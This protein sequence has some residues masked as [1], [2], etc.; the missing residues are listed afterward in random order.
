ME[1][2]TNSSE[3]EILF[4]EKCCELC[5]Y[6][7][8]TEP[9]MVIEYRNFENTP[10]DTNIFNQYNRTGS[11]VEYVV[12][13]ALLL[14]EN[15]P[16]LSKGTAQVHSDPSKQKK[17]KISVDPGDS[18]L[19][20]DTGGTTETPV[21]PSDSSS[22]EQLKQ[23]ALDKI[24]YKESVHKPSVE[25]NEERDTKDCRVSDSSLTDT[26]WPPPSVCG[27]IS[28]KDGKE[29]EKKYDPTEYQT[30]IT[31]ETMP[32]NNAPVAIT[33]KN[34]MLSGIKPIETCNNSSSCNSKELRDIEF[35]ST[36]NEDFDPQWCDPT[37]I[38]HNRHKTNEKSFSN[39]TETLEA[40]ESEIYTDRPVD[41][42][43]KVK[44]KTSGTTY[45]IKREI[46]ID[47]PPKHTGDTLKRTL[48]KCLLKSQL[49]R[50]YS[51]DL[52]K[53]SQKKALS[54]RQ[55]SVS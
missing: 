15:G 6:M 18:C 24:K 8:I 16:V 42:T 44:A 19:Q 53:R 26:A 10:M 14:H 25:T 46:P 35:I 55:H 21:C 4:V 51:V 33:D 31:S 23:N 13:P 3:S 17:S 22:K 41:T 52:D 54:D 50:Q 39:A 32:V 28:N 48:N 49:P 45:Y 2:Q 27:G 11:V 1:S 38:Q 12:W 40:D 47:K 20:Q 9:P 37:Y 5:W 36:E 29:D 43:I 34:P 30:D 7:C